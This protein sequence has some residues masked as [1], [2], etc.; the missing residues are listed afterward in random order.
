MVRK[1]GGEKL[2][3]II[4]PVVVAVLAFFFDI[5]LI[6]I[7]ERRMERATDYIMTNVLTTNVTDLRSRVETLY[8]ERDISIETLVVREVDGA[9]YIF[10]RHPFDA[11]FGRVLGTSQYFTE[12][13]VR[14]FYENG[15]VI[16]EEINQDD[17]PFEN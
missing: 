7:Q 6:H 2:F 14:G 12:V 3:L 15:E 8:E 16:I 1:E 11:F 13:S 10:N 17:F 5:L 9:I 4:I